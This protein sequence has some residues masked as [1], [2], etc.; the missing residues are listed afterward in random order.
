M[1]TRLL[2][3]IRRTKSTDSES[4]APGRTTN[5]TVQQRVSNT[6]K[7][8]ISSRDI[9]LKVVHI[10]SKDF[11]EYAN[12]A[13]STRSQSNEATYETN[14]NSGHTS[15]TFLPPIRHQFPMIHASVRRPAKNYRA[16][17][18]DVPQIRQAIL[19][20]RMRDASRRQQFEKISEI[21]FDHLNINKYVAR[22]GNVK[23]L[24]TSSFMNALQVYMPP[25]KK[26]TN[27]MM[28][29]AYDLENILIENCSESC[30]SSNFGKSKH[31]EK[32]LKT[33]P[34]ISHQNGDSET[35]DQVIIDPGNGEPREVN[36]DKENEKNINEEE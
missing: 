16:R 7:P 2:P 31:N 33:L 4:K 25:I 10:A 30:R 23:K 22:D 29:Q 34:L 20:F 3:P 11:N 24:N 28:S 26:K 13:S 19:D 12:D 35:T 15:G 17:F 1:A 27:K 21:F 36:V 9:H 18:G 32:N 5:A 8:L 6:L 14:S